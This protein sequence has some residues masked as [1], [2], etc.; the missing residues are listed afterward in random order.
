MIKKIL[1]NFVIISILV[2]LIFSKYMRFLE[3]RNVIPDFII[4]ITIINGIFN[5]PM[6][7]MLFGFAAGLA[8]DISSYPLLGFYALIYTIIGYL[9]SITK[10]FI[11]DNPLSSSILIFIFLLLKGFIYFVIGILFLNMQYI[12]NYFKNIFLIE[13]LY[14][15]IISIPIFLIYK[16]FYGPSRKIRSYE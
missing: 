7:G 13:L 1:V 9:T 6:Y 2:A 12:T 3:I 11:I 14:T 16:Q 8:L 15:L 5:G 10:L 4:I